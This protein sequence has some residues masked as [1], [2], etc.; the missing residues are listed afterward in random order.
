MKKISIVVPVYYN[1]LNLPHLFPRLFALAQA[2]PGY[3]FEYVFVDDGSGDNSFELLAEVAERD[4]RVRAAKLSRNFGAN[5]AVLAGLHYVSGDC[6]AM[7]AAD[8]QDPPEIISTMLRRWEAGKKVVLA[9]RNDR[10]DP[11]ISRLFAGMFYWLF[12]RMALK[13]MPAKGCDFLLIDR[14]V[15][16]MLV[17]IGEK[18][19]YLIGLVLWMGFERDIVYYKRQKREHGKSMW[20]FAK[21]TKYFI[22]A[23]V[24]FTYLPMRLISGLGAALALLGFVQA[25]IVVFNRMLY[26]VSPPGWT[27]LMVVILAVSGVQLLTLGIFGEYLWRNFEETRKRPPFI[28]DQVMGI[29]RESGGKRGTC[30]QAGSFVVEQ[31][32][33]LA[34]PDNEQPIV[35]K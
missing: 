28:V 7:I 11:F 14:T 10:E 5:A 27:S 3:E 22:D 8:L 30:E 20:S 18:N 17:Q 34:V 12:R 25:V 23:L 19:P 31:V 26:G 33:G 29:A 6:V 32:I 15:A 35:E 9:A 24:A 13:D 1:E 21:R 4:P 2:N 16:N